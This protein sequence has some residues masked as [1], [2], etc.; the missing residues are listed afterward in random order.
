MF[1]FLGGTT[2][3]SGLGFQ[4]GPNQ[5]PLGKE[6]LDRLKKELEEV[7]VVIVDEMSM[8][9]SDHFY[10][11]HKRLCQIF[12]SKDDFGGR[13]LLMVGDIMQLPPVQGK[14]IYSKPSFKKSSILMNM[15]NKQQEP[16]G[17][18]W[19]KL[20]VVVLKTNFRQGEGD[21][22]TE[23]LNRVRIGEPTSEDIEVLRSRKHTL[24]T[25]LQYEKAT[26]LFYTNPEVKDHNDY[27]LETLDTD[28]VRIRAK[29]DVPKG[30]GYIPSVNKWGI[31]DQTN[32]TMNLELKIGARIMLVYNVCI[33]DDLVNGT[34]GTIID[35]LFNKDDEV[36]SIIIAFDN[37]ET[38]LKQRKAFQVLAD[39]YSDQ[40]GCPIYKESAEYGIAYKS[41]KGK[42]QGK[43]HGAKWKL[44]QYPL[45]LAWG[46]TGHKVQGVSIKEGTDV[47][48]HGHKKMPYALMYMMLSRA[49]KKENV[50]LENFDPEQIRTDPN[51]LE[52][53]AKLD[54]RSI[55]PNYEKMHF[56]FFVLNVRS[57]RKHFDDLII[58]MFAQKSDHICM[59]ETWI[60]PETVDPDDFVMDGRNFDHASLGKGKGCGIFSINS[61]QNLGNL[62]V[63]K[64][65][66]QMLSIIDGS[67]QLIMVYLSSNC[68]KDEVV[69]DLKA[70]LRQDLNS[71][72][73][74][75]V[76]FDKGEKNE[77]TKYLASKQFQQLVDTPTHDSTA[78]TSART[79][80]HC[81]V[82]KDIVDK[83]EL[84]LHS[85]YYSDH[86]AL[87]ISLNL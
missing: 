82:S 79:I 83:I 57:L 22:W 70:I 39:N 64:E 68:S 45:R 43:T 73:V 13:A 49:E 52:E 35:I 87:C 3:H 63:V 15:K 28:L 23:L 78:T 54:D 76:N 66:Y 42:D 75:D 25:K 34:F 55:V 56:D 1:Y 65:K 62:K 29:C 14:P 84:R 7:E 6:K 47:V 74:G 5:E 40:N 81:Y 51:A 71:I 69:K 30:S 38:G 19:N 33:P 85:P 44:T 60:D 10:H 9:S 32:F 24:M 4:F 41:K 72:I 67:L 53:D 11:F 48:V 20:E 2:L 31:I 80:D 21:P 61:K 26:Q 8:V 46:S 50:F 77:L 86:D 36:E 16:I 37:P 58:D 27:M 12:D 59:L 17:D 18:L